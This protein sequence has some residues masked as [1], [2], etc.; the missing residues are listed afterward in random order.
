MSYPKK[1][2]IKNVKKR[3]QEKVTKLEKSSKFP[4]YC[5]MLILL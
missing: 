4:G 3:D 1:K 2:T 5:H